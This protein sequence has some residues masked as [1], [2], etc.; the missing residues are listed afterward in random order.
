MK[1]A[2]TDIAT[3]HFPIS[4][5]DTRLRALEGKLDSKTLDCDEMHRSIYSHI[6]ANSHNVQDIETEFNEK[7][8]ELVNRVE[9]LENKQGEHD[10][11]QRQY[12]ELIQRFNTFVVDINK[13]FETNETV[14]KSLLND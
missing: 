11:L 9:V 7:H 2:M 8:P 5:L 13:R 12:E 10:A 3:D 1:T 4:T 6:S 14:I